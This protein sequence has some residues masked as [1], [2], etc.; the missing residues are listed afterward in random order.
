MRS[1]TKKKMERPKQDDHAP[2]CFVRDEAVRGEGTQSVD[3]KIASEAIRALYNQPET[4][5]HAEQGRPLVTR[6]QFEKVMPALLMAALTAS[7][8]VHPP[9]KGLHQSQGRP[10]EQATRVEKKDQ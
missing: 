6:N 5:S 10:V 2:R 3:R 1:Q 9:G 4:C 7:A 8:C